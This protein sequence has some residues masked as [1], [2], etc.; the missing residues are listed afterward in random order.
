VASRVTRQLKFNAVGLGS[1]LA[2]PRAPP[3]PYGHAGLLI[4]APPRRDNAELT[5][6]YSRAS[7]GPRMCTRRSAHLF[8]SA[9][10]TASSRTSSIVSWGCW[11]RWMRRGQGHSLSSSGRRSA[12]FARTNND[13]VKGVRDFERFRARSAS[14]PM[15]P[16]KRASPA[17]TF[18][19][20]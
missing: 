17:R 4:R 2:R 20:H 9:S 18:H 8:P 16:T 5:N 14:R 3:F 15:T 6:R 7:T 19:C 13:I 1:T 12:P 10:H 11:G